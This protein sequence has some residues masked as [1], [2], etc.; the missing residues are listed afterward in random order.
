MLKVV[1]QEVTV[2]GEFSRYA[3]VEALELVRVDPK[4]THERFY[5]WDAPN[6]RGYYD[7]DGK[8]PFEGGWR[9]P[10]ETHRGR[11]RGIRIASIPCC[12]R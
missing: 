4:K 12:T 3:G 2:L 1:V 10:S 7:R 9:K 5:Y 8:A 6:V 11:R